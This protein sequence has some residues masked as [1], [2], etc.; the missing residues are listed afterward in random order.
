MVNYTKVYICYKKIFFIYKV[1]ENVT[2]SSQEIR[3]KLRK[4]RGT[5]IYVYDSETLKLLYIFDSKQHMYSSINIHHKTLNDCLDLGILY[6]NLFFLSL[7][8]LEIEDINL[9]T[10]EALKTLVVNKRDLYKVKHPAARAI[11]AEFKDDINKNLE[12]D[13][14]NSLAIHLKGDRQI[15]RDYL[16]GNRTGYYRGVWTFTYKN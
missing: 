8:L 11:L 1:A 3:N 4:E 13:S 16:K 2:D 9:L 7:D 6:L 5:P 12:F 15:I 10:L 14:L